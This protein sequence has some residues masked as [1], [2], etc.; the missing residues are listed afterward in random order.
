MPF[1]QIQ[2]SQ[3]TVSLQILQ[4]IHNPPERN[5]GFDQQGAAEYV[6]PQKRDSETG[7]LLEISNG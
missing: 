5:K 4:Q 6:W 2:E 3:V 7:I 1:K